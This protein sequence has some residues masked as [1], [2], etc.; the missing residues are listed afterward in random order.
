[1]FSFRAL[2]ERILALFKRKSETTTEQIVKN[3]E[4]TERYEDLKNVNITAIFANKLAALTTSESYVSVFEDGENRTQTRRSKLLDKALRGL[5]RRLKKITARMLGAGGVVI[6]PYVDGGKLCYDII[7]QDRMTINGTRGDEITAATVLAD[8][9][10]TSGKKYYRWVDYN[11]E[12]ETENGGQ[13]VLTITNKAMYN[14]AFV[15]LSSVPQWAG[16]AEEIRIA[17]VDKVIFAY[18]K[19]P[20]DNRKTSDNYGVPIT[21]GNDS[22]I[23]DIKETLEQINKEFDVKEVFVGVDDRLLDE[24]NKLPKS[25]MFR[26]FPAGSAQGKNAS[27]TFWEIFD[28]AIRDSSFYNKL[29]NQFALLEKAV[30]TSHGILTDRTTTTAT[31][32]ELKISNYDTFAML[33]SI[34]EVLENGVEDFLYACNV[35][36]ENAN[37]TPPSEYAVSIEWSYALIENSTETFQQLDRGYAIGAIKKAEIRQWLKSKETPENSQKAID[38]IAENEPQIQNLIGM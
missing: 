22:L 29:Q 6:I 1:M 25:R 32:T 37:L 10:V 24:R 5:W 23:A 35:L 27:G 38:Y 34:R 11:V 14:G 18:L 12:A 4:Y 30:G 8:T 19:S 9:C 15:P 33:E 20:V 2:W 26:K 21:Y 7:S 16:I 17:N 36:A 3:A 13:N 31:A 28:P